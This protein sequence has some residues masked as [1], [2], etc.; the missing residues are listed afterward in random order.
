MENEFGKARQLDA[1]LS[2]AGPDRNLGLLYQQAPG[3]P[4]SIGNRR[5]ARQH[6]EAAVQLAPDYPENRLNLLEAFLE[7]GERQNAE[8]ELQ[9]VEKLW[10]DAKKKLTGETW[11]SAWADWQERLKEARRQLARPNESATSPRNRNN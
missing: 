2:H 5:K 6:L 11:A 3:W 1:T 7:W 4:L 9:A 10:P 8:R